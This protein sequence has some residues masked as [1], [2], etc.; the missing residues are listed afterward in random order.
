MPKSDRIKTYYI[1][2]VSHSAGAT[3]NVYPLSGDIH[4]CQNSKHSY[5]SLNIKTH[6]I[7]KWNYLKICR[8]E[9]VGLQAKNNEE[10][11]EIK[12]KKDL[13]LK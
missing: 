13:F 7:W 12:G 8:F 4:L 9:C 2:N 1:T 6:W 10:K 11:M 5:V 3:S